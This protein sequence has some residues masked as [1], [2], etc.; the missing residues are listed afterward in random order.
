MEG[1]HYDI[2]GEWQ[3]IASGMGGC[4]KSPKHDQMSSCTRA[5]AGGVSGGTVAS[6]FGALFDESSAERKQSADPYCLDPP[7]SK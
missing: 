5:A 7:D 2:A 3:Y 1:V 4:L 6:L